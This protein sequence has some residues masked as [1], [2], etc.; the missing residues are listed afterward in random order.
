MET[1]AYRSPRRSFTH[2]GF[3]GYGE[4]VHAAMDDGFDA[5][6]VAEALDEA[7]T[8]V[9]AFAFDEGTN[10]PGCYRDADT[11][12]YAARTYLDPDTWVEVRI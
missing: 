3:A 5:A 10:Y 9:H 2:T 11:G 8:V 1:Y 4:A 7:L 6:D 12:E